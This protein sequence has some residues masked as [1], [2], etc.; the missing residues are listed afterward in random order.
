MNLNRYL[1]LQKQ[2]NELHKKEDDLLHQM[3]EVWNL[4]TDKE[5]DSIQQLTI[6]NNMKDLNS[7]E[8][9]RY[10]ET[11]KKNRV[12]IKEG[13]LDDVMNKQ[14]PLNQDEVDKIINEASEKLSEIL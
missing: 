11:F 1:H 9:V 14:I 4:L 13:V 7:D 6:L 12:V 8:Q 10:V 3:D 5:K 2:L